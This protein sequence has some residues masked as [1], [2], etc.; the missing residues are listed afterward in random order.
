[1]GRIPKRI[2][3]SYI[4]DWIV[5]LA[6]VVAGGVFSRITPNKRPFSPVD[7]SISF[8]F[9]HKEKVSTAVLVISAVIGP[10]IVIFLVCLLFIPGPTPRSSKW[11]LWQRKAWELNTGW[12]GL[13][14]SCAAAFLF[15]NGSKNLF[16]KPR[17]D[18]LS[19][20]NPDLAKISDYAV[21]GFGDKVQEGILLVSAAICKNTDKSRLNDGF[22]SFPSGHSSLSWAG[23]AYL[24]LFLSAKFAITIPYLAPRVFGKQIQRSSTADRVFDS[25]TPLRSQAA[26]PPLYL[27]I[28][29]VI[30]IG[31]ATYISSTRYSDFRHHGFD[32]L[33]GS[34]IGFVSAWFAFRWY[35]LPV[36]RG[37]G[38]AWGARSPSRAF[39]IGIGAGSYAGSEDSGREKTA[40]DPDLEGG[41]VAP[42]SHAGGDTIEMDDYAEETGAVSGSSPQRLNR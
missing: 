17:P 25:D 19:R 6:T 28:I 7:A 41:P 13:G 16:G 15:T 3:F 42:G 27:L 40:K 35:H 11:Q 8:P 18:L 31:A 12:L 10:G 22:R 37:A 32:I 38:Y 30:P 34:A 20:C 39:G 2:V 23:L 5:I 14:L 33:F 9:V 24:T 36:Q 1:M 29:A 26:A 21:G 4:L